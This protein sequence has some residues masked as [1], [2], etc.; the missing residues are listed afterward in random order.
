MKKNQKK[1]NEFASNAS[2]YV[3]NNAFYLENQPA[4]K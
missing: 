2:L 3:S 1:C 4:K